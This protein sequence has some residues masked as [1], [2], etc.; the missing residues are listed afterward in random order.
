[1]FAICFTF[2]EMLAFTVVLVFIF[3]TKQNIVKLFQ[4]LNLGYAKLKLRSIIQA[5][6]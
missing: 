3:F 5:K 4:N 6:M 2:Y 1:M